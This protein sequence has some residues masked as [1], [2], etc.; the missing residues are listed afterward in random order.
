MSKIVGELRVHLDHL[1]PRQS[2][3]YI[4][5]GKQSKITTFPIG[6]EATSEGDRALRYSDIMQEEGWFKQI[7]KPDFQR[8]S[9]A[10]TP[11]DCVEFLDS[12][13]RGRI[14]PSIILWHNH[15]N[16]LTYVLDGAHRLS[17]IRAWMMNDWGDKAGAYYERREQT[18]ITGAAEETRRL[19]I[20]KHIGDFKEYKRAQQE[21]L[22]LADQGKVQKDVMGEKRFTKAQFYNRVVGIHA[23]LAVQWE[24]GDYASAEQSFL[25]INRSGQ[26]LDPWEASLIEYRKSSYARAIMCIANGGEDGHYWPE[27][28]QEDE[29]IDKELV[30]LVK[31]FSEK[32]A[33]I[34]KRLFVPPLRLPVISEN[35]PLM[36][37]PQYFQKHKYLLE[38]V[39]LIVDR[40]IATTEEQ[41]IKNMAKDA[42][43]PAETVIR[44]ADRILSTMTDRLEHVVSP[45]HNSKS[46]SIVPLFYWYNQKT[47]YA[48]GLFYGFIYWLLAGSDKDITNRKLVFSVNRDRF[49]HLLFHFKREI[50]TLQEKGGAGLNATKRVA[51]FFQALLKLL[52]DNPKLPAESSELEIAIW[53]ILNELGR[54]PSRK[55]KAKTSRN[56]STKDKSQINTR[57]LFQASI[58]CHICGGVLSLQQGLQYDHTEDYALTKL[59]DPETGKPTHPFCNRNKKDIFAYKAGEKTLLLPSFETSIQKE[60]NLYGQLSLFDFWGDDNFPG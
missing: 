4:S 8:E 13:V 25:R 52:H 34:Y 41:Q 55:P 37:A 33:D 51:K 22:A 2:I 26:A 58:R 18:L 30:D 35:V 54:V 14:I 38:V 42:E 23:T 17:V 50:A 12:V 28:S 31:G 60:K 40:E 19:L 6:H 48:R 11:V 27:P 57:E 15:D 9:N 49:E 20:A 10:W 3:R 16:G 43:A 59:T 21:F 36:V 46:L 7:R 32:A 1:I 47:D 56:H 24:H 39:P 5:P 53:E 45:T 29:N 44:N